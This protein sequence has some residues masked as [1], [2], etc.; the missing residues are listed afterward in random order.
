MWWKLSGEGPHLL[1]HLGGSRSYVGRTPTLEWHLVPFILHRSNQREHQHSRCGCALPARRSPAKGC[2]NTPKAIPFRR[3]PGM[4]GEVV[5]EGLGHVK[6]KRSHVSA[7]PGG[8]WPPR[9]TKLQIFFEGGGKLAFT[10]S[11][12]C[13]AHSVGAKLSAVVALGA[14]LLKVLVRAAGE[15][16]GRSATMATRVSRS[17]S[18]L[19]SEP[20]GAPPSPQLCAR[21][22]AGRPASPGAA[23]PAGLGRVRRAAGAGR[24]LCGG[25]AVASGA[26]ACAANQGAAAAAGGIARLCGLGARAQRTGPGRGPV[27][28]GLKGGGRGRGASLRVLRAWLGSVLARTA[29]QAHARVYHV[30]EGT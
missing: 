29:R 28:A 2:S 17:S 11:R 9:F 12:R 1:L 10:D 18:M 6:Y 13:G 7:N 15:P 5:V 23:Q 22:A 14:E 3:G 4:T 24:G 26:G 21:A 27:R 25:G 30:Q 16:S 20:P 19:D 8:E